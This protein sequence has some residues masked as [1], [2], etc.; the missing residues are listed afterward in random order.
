MEIWIKLRLRAGIVYSWFNDY[1]MDLMSKK[2]W[3]IPDGHEIYL[4]SE[5]S[6]LALGPSNHPVK[7]V[8]GAFSQ[9]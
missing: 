6:R 9:R 4:F 8:M 5:A 1:V 7:W 2:L 3:F